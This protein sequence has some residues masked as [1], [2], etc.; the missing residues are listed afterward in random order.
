MDHVKVLKR[1]WYLLWHYRV[2]WSFGI[3]L[4]LVT[5]GGGNSGG[6]QY[7]FG[8]EDLFAGGPWR[9]QDIPRE[10]VSA[11]LAVGVG[12]VCLALLMAVVAT[13]ARYV[14]ETALIRMV[15]YHEQTGERQTI[16]QGIRFGW[17]RVAL[18]LFLIDLAI[19]LPVFIVVLILPLI[20]A[21]PL[22]LWATKAPLLGALGTI[23]AI[24]LG[25][26][27]ITLAIVV[28]VALSILTR[29]FRRACALEQRGVLESILRGY[30]M[31]R[32]HPK[33]V[34]ITWLITLGLGLAWLIAMVPVTI[35]LLALGGLAGG[36]PALMVGWLTG[37]V[38]N[39]VIPWILA[40][41]VGLP[42]LILVVAPPL[43][44]LGGLWQVFS[45]SVWTLTYRKL[46]ALERGESRC[47][48]QARPAVRAGMRPD[49]D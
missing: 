16:R 10:V 35:L 23:A 12:L 40:F 24:S 22:L 42:V 48:H 25:L 49:Q 29:L 3:I 11:L 28:G 33:D 21:A 27:V 8:D 5:G 37:L 47:V 7:T 39:G 31:A 38:S 2:L 15:D 4:A 43:V 1:A 18:R 13:I 45:S 36:L 6:F 14:A 32:R 44:L 41:V 46:C 9:P 19:G 20:A 26:L 30:R 17:S 34:A